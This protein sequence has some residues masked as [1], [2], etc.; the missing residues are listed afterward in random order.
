MQSAP[1]TNMAILANGAELTRNTV[2]SMM[3]N[4]NVRNFFGQPAARDTVYRVFMMKVHKKLEGALRNMPSGQFNK[5][6]RTGEHQ[7]G[8]VNPNVIAK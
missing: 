4:E 3:T 7:S 5:S 8:A 2:A 6:V 1:Q